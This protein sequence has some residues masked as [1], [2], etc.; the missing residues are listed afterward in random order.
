M[1]LRHWDSRV[2]WS[3]LER[4]GRLDRGSNPRCPITVS[5]MRKILILILIFLAHVASGASEFTLS[6]VERPHG[7]VLLIVDGLGSSYF[8]PELSPFALDGSELPKVMAPNLT[9]GTRVIMT[10]HHPR[11]VKAH[12]IIVTGDSE[13]DQEIVGY[14][15]ATIFDI[16]RK[17]GYLN[18]AVM[19]KGDFSEMRKEQDIIMFAP[20]NSIKKPNISIQVNGKV[21]DDVY[22]VMYEWKT[23]LKE[24]LDNTKGVERYAAYNKWGIDAANAIVKDMITHHPHKKFLLTVNIGAVDAGG[25]NLGREGYTMLIK[26][27]DRDFFTLYETTSM[28]NIA[29]FLTADHGMC[30]SSKNAKRGGHSSRKYSSKTESLSIPFVIF[31]P[32]TVQG[33]I[34]GKYQQQDIAPTLLSVLDLPNSLRYADGRVIHV[35]RYATL[36]VITS[37]EFEVSLWK[38]GKKIAEASDSEFIYAGIPINATYT[39]KA[40]SS[41]KE[42]EKTVFLD[43]DKQI[44]FERGDA[45]FNKREIIALMLIIV[46]ITT[47]IMTIKRMVD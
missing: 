15:D 29:L 9:S 30:F 45:V 3:I 24:Y 10:T 13:A 18:L 38:G 7:A 17:H 4:L 19:Q 35:K 22:N 1:L 20:T 47:G 21:Y 36:F 25:H 46:V 8:Y 44:Y 6:S 43:T 39:I 40:S 5:C 16:T 42:Y 26:N 33:L 41:G 2:A 37:P 34:E 28:N 11:T 32:N 27:L 14:R 23:K 31:S 12:S